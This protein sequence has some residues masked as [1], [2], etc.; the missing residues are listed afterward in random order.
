[1]ENGVFVNEAF[2][3][4][5]MEYLN[6]K[7]N[8]EG[9]KFNS[10]LVVVIRLLTIIYDELDI[11]N[12]YYLGNE[13]SLDNNMRKY[14]YSQDELIAFKKAFERFYENEGE[15]N[16][17]KIQRMLIDMFAKK[18]K[19]LNV[20]N[21]E[22]NA[23]KGLLY[24]PYA[25]NPL[26][27]SYN[28]LMAKDPMEVITYFEKQMSENNKKVISRPKETLNLEAY[29]ILKYSLEDIKGMTSE[30]LDEVNKKV[31]SYFDINANAI[32]KNYLL[33]KAVFNYNN[34][35]P[36][37]STGNGYVDILFFLAIAATVGMV[38]L[39]ITLFV[40]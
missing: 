1:M 26:L 3:K 11:L 9:I 7:N 21:E 28:F 40:L 15:T 8:P 31:Y 5:L 39:I 16:F 32:N 10:F 33:D 22:I 17:I 30:E 27:V 24:S 25:E 35:K 12:P 2:T 4:A 14:G 18:K 36:A 20:S 6:N 29:E 23:F 38:I 13:Q 34:P 37:L 19:S